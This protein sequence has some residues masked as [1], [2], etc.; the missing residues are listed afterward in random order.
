MKYVIFEDGTFV[1]LPKTMKHSDAAVMG[2]IKSAGFC[3]LTTQVNT[4]GEER[5]R[6][7]CWGKSETLKLKSNPKEDE[8]IINSALNL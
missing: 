3:R 7:S 1:L 5:L 6:A 4:Y 2:R 8:A